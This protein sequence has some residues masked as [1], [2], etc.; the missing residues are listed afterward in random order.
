MCQCCATPG[1][2]RHL[3]LPAFALLIA[4]T[5]KP[6]CMAPE[7][8]AVSL[9]LQGAST[10]LCSGLKT[11]QC[12]QPIDCA[13]LQGDLQAAIISIHEHE[14]E[15]RHIEYSQSLHIN[16]QSTRRVT[17]NH[18]VPSWI[19]ACAAKSSRPTS[20]Y[21]HVAID[22]VLSSTVPVSRSASAPAI[23]G[24]E[25]CCVGSMHVTMAAAELLSTINR[26]S[27]ARSKLFRSAYAH[28]CAGGRSR[29]SS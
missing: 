12:S 15:H 7:T 11:T 21:V 8:P 27:S 25:T 6:L 4:A 1:R 18:V 3:Q 19:T 2:P 14:H 28:C 9:H 16:V 20:S 10:F 23:L 13:S 5:H 29:I 17:T 26:R 24:T 22:C